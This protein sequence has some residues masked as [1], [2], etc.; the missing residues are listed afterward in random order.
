MPKFLTTFP[1]ASEFEKA[2]AV[3]GGLGLGYDILSPEPAY[4]RVGV[5]C[6][7][8]DDTARMALAEHD[9]DS[10]FVCSGWVEHRVATRVIPVEPPPT[11]AEDI[12]GTASVMVL[13]PCVADLSRIR[14]TAH[15]SGD[16]A[17]VFPYLNSEMREGS[18]TPGGPTFT[19][20]DQ[21]R[22]VCLYSR[23]ITMAK[24]DDIVD[25]WGVLEAIRCRVNDVWGR[26]H[27]ISPSYER[28]ER[29]PA[30]EIYKRLPRTNCR[31]C[32]ELTCLAF[33]AHLWQGQTNM[34]ECRPVFAGTHRHLKPALIDIC[35]GLGVT[36]EAG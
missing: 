23:R 21:Y 25:A 11:H 15:L 7:I 31:E 29:P 16:L 32:G 9:L 13:A 17:P 28:R 26:R 4:G 6:V 24:A 35:V 27:E 18:Y 30:L 2:Q 3:F 5:P 20:M 1:Q 8:V 19:F 33:A 14:I 10:R 22:M 34:T 12:F 36:D